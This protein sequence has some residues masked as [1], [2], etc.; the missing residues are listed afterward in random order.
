MCEWEGLCVFAYVDHPVGVQSDM[1]V[2]ICKGG[3]G[4]TDCGHIYA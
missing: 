1:V 4:V 3:I 2:C